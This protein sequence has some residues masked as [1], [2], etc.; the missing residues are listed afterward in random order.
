MRIQMGSFF[1]VFKPVTRYC[2]VFVWVSLILLA[3]VY[4]GGSGNIT[5][6]ISFLLIGLATGLIAL[7][8]LVALISRKVRVL[9]LKKT[10]ESQ[11]F[12]PLLVMV[13]I[14]VFFTTAVV[15]AGFLL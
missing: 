7:Y 1:D 15:F 11:Y 13:L 4:N 14:G 6:K 3:I 5:S 10:E 2:L 8:C 9:T 12:A